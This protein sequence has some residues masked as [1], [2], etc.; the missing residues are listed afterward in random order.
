MLV[1]IYP[2]EGKVLA[3][4][5]NSTKKKEKKTH[6]KNNFFVFPNE[7]SLSSD[8]HFWCSKSFLWHCTCI[9]TIIAGLGEGDCELL[10]F[11]SAS[12][13]HAERIKTRGSQYFW[14]ARKGIKFSEQFKVELYHLL[15]PKESTFSC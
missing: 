5:H 14:K 3:T 15:E 8:G 7:S 11:V 12:G 9:L 1:L 2:K 6:I 4:L 10:V 13:R